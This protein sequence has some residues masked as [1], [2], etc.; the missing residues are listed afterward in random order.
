M[1]SFKHP[2]RRSV[3]VEFVIFVLV[4]LFGTVFSL[5]L[6]HLL[7]Q[8]GLSLFLASPISN[9]VAQAIDFFPHKLLSFKEQRLETRVLSLEVLLYTTVAL[10]ML[11]AEPVL[12][13]LF[14]QKVGLSPLK[15]WFAVHPF[16]GTVRFLLYRAIFKKFH[17]YTTPSSS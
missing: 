8:Q 13:Y 16:T 6:Y 7:R 15:A 17:Q 9:L 12:L 14:E 3:V 11:V 5:P 2:L 1:E 10:G 4:S